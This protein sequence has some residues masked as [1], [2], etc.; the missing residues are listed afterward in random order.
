MGPVHAETRSRLHRIDMRTA[1][2]CAVML[3]LYAVSLGMDLVF[4]TR[5]ST[6]KIY[7]GAIF[8]TFLIPSPRIVVALTAAGLFSLTVGF[9]VSQFSLGVASMGGADRALAAA[10]MCFGAW[11]AI[12][13]QASTQALDRSE[14]ALRE[15]HE[16]AQLGRFEVDLKS[17]ALVNCSAECLQVLGLDS[18]DSMPASGWWRTVIHPRDRHRVGRQVVSALRQGGRYTIEFRIVRPSGVVRHVR[19]AGLVHADEEGTPARLA[20]TLLDISDWREAERSMR[21]SEARMKSILDT[22]PDAMVIIDQNGVITTFSVSA[23]ALF[24]YSASEAVGRNVRMLMPPPYRDRHDD[25][26]R[27]RPPTGERRILRMRREFAGLRKDGSVFPIEL[28][29][30]ELVTGQQRLFIG[31]IRDLTASRRMEEELRRSQKIEAIGQLTGGVAHDFNNLLTVIMGNL[32]MLEPQMTRQ[33]QRE[34]VREARETAE[35]GAQLTNRLL[36][37]GRRPSLTPQRVE[38]VTFLDVFQ[39]RLRR[40][41]GDSI[42]L[43][44]RPMPELPPV[45]IDPSQLQIALFNLVF[46]A[47]DAMPDGGR[48]LISAEEMTIDSDHPAEEGEVPAGRYVVVAVADTGTGMAPEVREHALEPFFTTK[49]VGAGSGL[50]L[51]M[52]YGFVTQSNGHMRIDSEPGRGTTIRLHLPCAPGT[53]DSRAAPDDAAPARRSLDF[54]QAPHALRVKPGNDDVRAVRRSKNKR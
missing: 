10:I 19:S 15:T 33:R 14:A 17:G 31:F 42:D 9:A 51:S 53:G 50:G 35:L 5:F 36:A 46:N 24:G 21:E 40:A 37:F 8:L 52:V 41:L 54:L 13:Y 28:T 4:P 30:S 23:E 48:I 16:I 12:R 25:Y 32:E 39:T 38:L 7:V 34:L 2:V 20:G 49:D 18:G 6:G 43:Q 29:V 22:V 44:V 26:L 47:R 1:L 45:L 27:R 3:C 11:L